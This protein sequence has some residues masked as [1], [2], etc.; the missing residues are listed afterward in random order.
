M[1]SLRIFGKTDDV[2]QRLMKELKFDDHVYK[3]V[4]HKWTDNN[5][6]LVPYDKQGRRNEADGIRKMWLDLTEGAKIRITPGH[7]IQ[8]AKQPVYM[9]IGANKPHKYKGQVR[10]PGIGRGTVIR[11]DSEKTC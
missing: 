1:G 11:R 8:G 5:K 2:L 3:G 10:Q 7:N 4:S 6:A 9:H